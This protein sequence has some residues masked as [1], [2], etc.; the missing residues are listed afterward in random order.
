[1]FC[2]GLAAGL[3]AWRPAAVHALEPPK[4]LV[5]VILEQFRPDYLARLQSFLSPGGFRRLMSEGA[6]FP[7]CSQLASTFPSSA[8]ATLATGAYPVVHGVV[9]DT[10]YDRASRRPVSAGP[11]ELQATTLAD[12]VPADPRNRIFAVGLRDDHL[13]LL[14]GNAAAKTIAMD[15]QGLFAARGEQPA[16]LAEFNRRHA[17]ERRHNAQWRAVDAAPSAPPLRTLVYNPAHAEDFLLLYQASPYAQAAQFD[18]LRELVA[19]EKLGQ[20]DTTDYLLVSLGSMAELGYEVGAE[21]PLMNQMVLH[22]DRQMEQ[23]LEAL[24]KAPGTG[25]FALAVAGAHG[26][27]PEPDAA[28][29]GL[30]A[31]SGETVARGI[32]QWLTD[33][34]GGAPALYVEKYVYPFLYLNLAEFRKRNIEPPRARRMAGE[35][36]LGVHGVAGYYTADGDSSYASAWL[37]RFRNS[38]HAVRSGDVMLAYLPDCVEDTGAGRGISYGSLYN[39]DASVPLFLYGGPF[40]KRVI[41][42][43]VHA[44]DVAPTLARVAGI[45]LPSSAIGRVLGEALGPETAPPA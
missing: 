3:A 29:R 35:A 6:W 25:R 24:N 15:T 9:A 32:N 36:A 28:V 37:E 34:V 43:E 13:A 20:G 14:L 1:M 31:I 22:L 30:L 12:Q 41:E 39:Y 38:F 33:R 19:Q 7:N 2:G 4:L 40:R 17:P 44:V 10:W 18:L 23:T 11:A 27:P 8:L 21:S 5:F 42:R 26:A 16:W 45:S